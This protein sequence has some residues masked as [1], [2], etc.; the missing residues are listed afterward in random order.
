MPSAFTAVYDACVLYPAPLRDLLLR[1][2]GS[3][4]FRARWTAEINEEWFRNLR[5]NRS[6]IPEERLRKL[7]ELV[8]ESVSDCLITGYEALVPGLTLPDPDDRHV[9]AAAIRAGAGVIVT[10]NVDDFP[11]VE[12]ATYGI[13]VQDPDTF[14]QHLLDLAPPIVAAVVKE[15]RAALRNPVR[16][17]EELLA[18]FEQQQLVG[19]VARL[20]EMIAL[21]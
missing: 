6:D 16:S 10:Y 5:Q 12:L 1:L 2:G 17:A 3:G 20:R 9:L 7:V 13:E 19:S 4:L 8:N 18:T 11:A 21:L 15:Q 14:I